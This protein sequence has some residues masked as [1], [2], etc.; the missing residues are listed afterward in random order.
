[1][2]AI[3]GTINRQGV[4]FA[5]DSAAT[6]A[7]SSTCKITNHA[8]KIFEL[9]R[10]HPVGICICGGGAFIGVP[11]EEI[12]KMFRKYIKNDFLPKLTDYSNTFFNFVRSNLLPKLEHDQKDLLLFFAN[13]F[14]DE[15]AQTIEKELK[16]KGIDPEDNVA[17]ADI[18]LCQ[19]KNCCKMST[20]LPRSLDYVQ[21]SQKE[22]TDYA[23]EDIDIFLHNKLGALYSTELKEQFI[24]ALYLV[25]TSDKHIYLNSSELI[26]WGYGENELFPSY[27]SYLVSLA[28]DGRIKY[29]KKSEY[30]VSN[31]AHAC[32]EPFAQTDVANTVVRGIDDNLRGVFYD[33]H[34]QS[35]ELFKNSIITELKSAAAPER[36]ITA[37]NK[38]D[39]KQ[40]TE[41]YASHMNQY[42][43]EKYIDQLVQTV[44]YLS[45]EDLADMAESLV[46]M[47]SLKRHITSEEESVGGAVDVA[48]ITKGD[49]FIWIK[50]K[51]YF[52]AELNP[53]YFERSKNL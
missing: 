16:E 19:L 1:M 25:L 24:N 11:W 37:L 7:T 6:H 10:H 48:V 31:Q 30:I 41:N 44:S 33:T 47:T 49:G 43:Q 35:F 50:R 21:Y 18:M 9:S 29:T 4:A 36:L 39:S 23:D 34:N 3:V 13:C 12:F 40:Y 15:V 8:N 52:E 32:V 38:I 2:T 42:I 27:V 22:F 17:R 5:A 28:F 53:H 51:H 46:R 14:Y 26:F 20:Q 45:K